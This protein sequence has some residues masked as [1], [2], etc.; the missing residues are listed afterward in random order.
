MIIDNILV[1]TA[2]SLLYTELWI[3]LHVEQL[4]SQS[5]RKIVQYCS[6]IFNGLGLIVILYLIIL[7]FILAHITLLLLV[8]GS[9]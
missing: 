4:C 2:L 3:I 5:S 9:V 8:I 6:N 7:S 1:S